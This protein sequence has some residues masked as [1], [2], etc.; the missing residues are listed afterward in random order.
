MASWCLTASVMQLNRPQRP[1]RERSS[2]TSSVGMDTEMF[3]VDPARVHFMLKVQ[4]SSIAPRALYMRTAV[5]S[6]VMTRVS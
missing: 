2:L 3:S 6:R 4:D 1:V 5:V